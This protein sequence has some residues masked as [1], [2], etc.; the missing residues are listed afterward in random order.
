MTW[1]LKITY[2]TD[3]SWRPRATQFQRSQIIKKKQFF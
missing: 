2:N 1:I 3:W